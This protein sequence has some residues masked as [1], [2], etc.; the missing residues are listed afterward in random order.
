MHSAKNMRDYQTLLH[1]LRS[2]AEALQAEDQDRLT[3]LAP[4]IADYSQRVQ[5]GAERLSTLTDEQRTELREL[6]RELLEQ[7][8]CNRRLWQSVVDTNCCLRESHRAAKR[9]AASVRSRQEPAT[10]RFQ[11]DG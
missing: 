9:Y 8:E 10:P 5:A 1:L 11:V 6:L 4:A 7:V 2:Q 3:A